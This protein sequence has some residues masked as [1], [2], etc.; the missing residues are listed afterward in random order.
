MGNQLCTNKLNIFQ[1]IKIKYK[2]NIIVCQRKNLTYVKSPQTEQNIPLLY[3]Q[4]RLYKEGFVEEL[5]YEGQMRK[6]KFDGYGKLYRQLKLVYEGQF[7]DNV[8][9]G[10]GITPAY[11]GEFRQGQYDGYGIYKEY[12]D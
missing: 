5:I 8:F 4:V 6:S 3:G 12:L 11:T 7:K 1:E 2:K 10:W 9:D